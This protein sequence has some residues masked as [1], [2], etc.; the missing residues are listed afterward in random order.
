MY[1]NI[2]LPVD[3]SI[4]SKRALEHVKRMA[5]VFNSEVTVLC[6]FH[7]PYS[8]S[9]SFVNLPQEIYDA[10][11]KNNEIEAKKLVESVTSELTSMNIDSSPLV[12]EGSPKKMICDYAKR[13]DID[14]IIMGTK[15]HTEGNYIGSTSTYVINHTNGIPVMV[16]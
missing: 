4:H 6:V 15:G 12:L 8:V 3:G 9:N 13:L 5:K 1:N 11:K 2:L 10:Y 7:R 14:L 16:V